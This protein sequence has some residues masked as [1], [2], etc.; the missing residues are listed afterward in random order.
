MQWKRF[1][2]ST[3][4]MCNGYCNDPNVIICRM[5]SPRCTWQLIM[6]TKMWLSCCWKKEPRLMPLQRLCKEFNKRQNMCCSPFHCKWSDRVW[7]LWGLARTYSWNHA[8]LMSLLV[9][10]YPLTPLEWLHP[11]PHCSQEEPDED[12]ISAAAAW[13]RDKHSDQAGGQPSAPGSAGGPCWDGEPT[14]RKGSSRQRSH[15]GHSHVQ[16]HW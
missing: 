7:D 14:A 12:R 8:E 6:T 11:S 3:Q 15:Q 13:R 10:L 5:A 16:I 1:W 9:T 4:Q 2:D